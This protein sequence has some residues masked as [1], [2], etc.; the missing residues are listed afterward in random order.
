MIGIV[1]TRFKQTVALVG[2][3]RHRRS[4]ILKLAPPGGIVVTEPIAEHANDPTLV[5]TTSKAE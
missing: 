3:A 5:R 2:P 1:G 4:R